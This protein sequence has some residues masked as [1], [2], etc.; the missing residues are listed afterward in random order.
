ML[1]GMVLD[2][3]K[4]S[5]PS[6]RVDLT[7]PPKGGAPPVDNLCTTFYDSYKKPRKNL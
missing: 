6:K 7:D 3:A 1:L 4:I 5:H 2:T